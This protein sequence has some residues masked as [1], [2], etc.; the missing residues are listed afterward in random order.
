[1]D[2]SAQELKVYTYGDYLKFED[3]ARCE[4]IGGVI[5]N[6]SP[7]PRSR[8][9]QVLW[10]LSNQIGNYFEG[11]TC[12]MFIAPFDVRLPKPGEKS[13]S[14][15]NVVQ[16]DI[17]VVC[18]PKKIDFRGCKGVPD[19]I[20]E[21]TSPSTAKTDRR[22]KFMLYEETGVKEYWI[23][24]PEKNTLSVFIREKDGM[25]GSE[26]VFAEHQSVAPSSFPEL[27]VDLNRVFVK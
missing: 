5:Y 23:V 9:Q 21:I 8:H 14:A 27:R 15:T 16:P 3:H 24:N 1:V 4:I 18:D 17:V 6:M 10:R 13:L 26:M 19:W 7:A 22:L 20:I 2:S 12:Q 25:Y 11:K